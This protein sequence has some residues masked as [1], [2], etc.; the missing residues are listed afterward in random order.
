VTKFY[1]LA[2]DDNDDAELFKEALST[3]DPPI[4]CVHVEDGKS[5]FQFLMDPANRK[6]DI[7]FLDLNMPVMN[8]WQCL[9]KLKN[10]LTFQEI[11]VIMY[12]TSS[13]YRD[14]EIAKELGALAFFTKPSN[15]NILLSSLE[16]IARQSE[17]NLDHLEL[18][19][20]W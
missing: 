17:K 1:L 2:D 9:A 12:S 3:I 5:V 19:S 15:F 16:Y 20:N 14:K 7:I 18:K 13:H 8:G 6:P 11:P 4:D 10:D